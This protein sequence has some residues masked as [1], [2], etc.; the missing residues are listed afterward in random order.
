MKKRI[1]FITIILLSHCL[2][3]G[4]NSPMQLELNSIIKDKKWTGASIACQF[5]NQNNNKVILEH[6][7]DLLLAPA[8]VTKVI[9]TAAALLD[10]G[11]DFKFET[12]YSYS[13]IIRHDTLFGNLIVRG[14]GDPTTYSEYF[15]KHNTYH[16]FDLLKSALDKW[17]IK[18]I[19]GDL[20]IIDTL[21]DQ[22]FANPKWPFEDIGNYYGAGA[23]SISYADNKYEI[24]LSKQKDGTTKVKSHNALLNFSINNQVI[25][26]GNSDEAYIYASP[27]NTSHINIYGSIPAQVSEYSIYGSH[28]HP[29]QFFGL[30]LK[31]FLDSNHLADINK[32]LPYNISAISEKTLYK[33]LSP[34]LN[35]IVFYTNQ[36]SDNHYAECL[37]KYLGVKYYQKGTFENGLK[38]LTE[39][40]KK[41]NIDMEVIN[42]YDGCGLA[43]SN[44]ISC[45]FINK[46]LKLMSD[47]QSLKNGFFNSLPLSG[48]QGS[49]RSFGKATM[50][51]N[52]MRAKTGYIEKVRA[53]SGQF[54]NKGGEN[55]LFT[56]MI[57]NYT[58]SASEARKVLEQICLIVA[59]Q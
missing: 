37:F 21:F 30:H 51:E 1:V 46:I 24:I 27:L 56:V 54:K 20:C 16:Q 36:E 45:R 43:R 3:L 7:A 26:K 23:S 39:I 15:S 32:I 29:A 5:Y 44:A 18:F 34:P 22:Q 28:P 8:S 55:I 49:M 9:T 42:L 13:G 53:Y 14:G 47:E 58:G 33:H 10:L 59:K 57:N 50:L 17:K 11:L 12:G 25:S 19:K 48:K 4:Q 31:Q 52:N 2:I 6:Q 38:A 40:Y 35:D 41:H